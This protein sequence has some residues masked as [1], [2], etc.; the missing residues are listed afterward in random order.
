VMA[1]DVGG[2]AEAMLGM[3]YL[4]P[5]NPVTRYRPMVDELMVPAV[6]IPPQDV[7]P[8]AAVLKRLLT[9]RAHYEDLSA[10]SRRTALEYA[11]NLNAA[12]FEAY[13]E[14]ILQSPKRRA[15]T[16]RPS[17]RAPLSD[18]RRQLLALRLKRAN[19]HVGH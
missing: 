3:D 18:E 19:T 9:D 13:L 16:R 15:S 5:V 14:K 1:S 11:R 6:D 4:L 10:G 8:W 17:V 7:G 12:P 2:L